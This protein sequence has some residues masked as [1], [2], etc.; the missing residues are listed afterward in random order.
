MDGGYLRNV[1]VVNDGIDNF[2]GPLKE[3]DNARWYTSL[4][5]EGCDLVHG[6]WYLFTG[7]QDHGIAHD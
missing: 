5:Q 6:K 1:G 4:L 7:L 2:F 3:V